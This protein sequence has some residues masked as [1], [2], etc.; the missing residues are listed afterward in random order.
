MLSLRNILQLHQQRISG[1]VSI[2]ASM[3]YTGAMKLF[4]SEDEIQHGVCVIK[5]SG[6]LP[7]VH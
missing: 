1:R 5:T 4:P 2:I 6:S 7:P 3:S